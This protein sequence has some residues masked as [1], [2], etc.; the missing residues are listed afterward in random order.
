MTLLAFGEA[1]AL[2]TLMARTAKPYMLSFVIRKN[3]RLLDGTPLRQVIEE[4]DATVA[5]PPT[6][7]GVNCV[8][9]RVFAA[10]L[11]T[12]GIIGTSLAERIF[13]LCANTSAREPEE[14]DGLDDLDTED[15]ESFAASMWETYASASSKY[16]GGCC[17]TSTAHIEAIARRWSSQNRD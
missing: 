10:G 2:A 17:G 1:F 9:P 11:Q 16:L 5:Q 8:H 14:L 3:G 13:G 7:Y 6:G 12:Q 15:P 4:I